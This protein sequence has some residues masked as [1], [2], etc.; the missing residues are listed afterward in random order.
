MNMSSSYH[1]QT[2]GQ[3][4]RPNQCLETYLRCL[5]HAKPKEWAKWLPLAMYWY[6]TS[7][8]SALGRSPFEVLYG[9][10]P[11][12]F[13]FQ[14]TE[15]TGHTDLDEWLTERAAMMPVIRQHLER[16]QRRMKH[17]AD[18][19]REERSFQIG[20]WVYLKLQPYVQVSVAQRV[21]QKLG[22]KFFGPYEIIGKVGNVSYK[23]K[24]P[25]SAR[26][27]PVIHV[28]QLKKAIRPGDTVSTDL[29]LSSLEPVLVQPSRV[30]GE[31]LV[32]RGSK[33]VPQVKVHWSG[34]PP[35]CTSWEPLFAVVNAFPHAPAW[36]Q[37]GTPG[38]GIVTL[39]Y[40]PEAIK[41]KQR[42]AER[43]RIREAH[44]ARMM[45]PNN[46]PTP[47]PESEAVI[48]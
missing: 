32:R 47:W 8:H 26:I 24:L 25:E 14:Q 44:L 13:G 35:S 1:P 45:K 38:G 11:R 46:G 37:A 2:D 5:V 28:S 39:R 34:M 33:L 18:K 10:Q 19:K 20:D 7:F 22:F 43:Q 17:Q 40:L 3:T 4:E 42:T 48:A 12:H 30:F 21:S 31:R 27:H 16:A 36:G 15:P 23:L 29:P 6:N 9:R 41:V